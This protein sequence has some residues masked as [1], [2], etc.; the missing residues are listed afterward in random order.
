MKAVK[1]GSK[2]IVWLKDADFGKV[3][4]MATPGVPVKWRKPNHT[5]ERA[6]LVRIQAST[7]LKKITLPGSIIIN[8]DHHNRE[9]DRSKLVEIDFG[10]CYRNES[11]YGLGIEHL[12]ESLRAALVLQDNVRVTCR[13]RT[14]LDAVIETLKQNYCEPRIDALTLA[15]GEPAILTW[16]SDGLTWKWEIFMGTY[17]HVELLE[18]K[19][20]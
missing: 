8:S 6:T 3:V 7:K 18:N 9:I 15:E 16:K 17:L 5:T 11:T 4:D 2:S 13:N 12:A 1:E 14:D 19:P 10:S 20:C